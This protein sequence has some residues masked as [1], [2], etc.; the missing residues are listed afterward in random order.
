[1]G[2]RITIPNLHKALTVACK[3][4]RQQYSKQNS[5]TTYFTDQNSFEMKNYQC[6]KCKTTIQNNSTPSSL[7]CPGGGMHSWTN[8]GDV[9]TNNYQCKKCGTLV[10]SKSTP[11]SLN[12]PSGS[13]HSWTKL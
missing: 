13:M 9:G 4:I 10:K 6:K 8:L 2:G 1:V 12:C 11:S 5:Q 7:N 3:F